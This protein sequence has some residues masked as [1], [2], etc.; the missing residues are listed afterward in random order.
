M[1]KEVEGTERG[2]TRKEE[3]K[4]EGKREDIEVWEEGGSCDLR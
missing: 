2:K 4:R 3:G 1:E